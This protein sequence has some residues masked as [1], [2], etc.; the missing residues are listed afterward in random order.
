MT[1]NNFKELVGVI[2]CAGKGVRLSTKTKELQKCL[3]SIDGESIL[4]KIFA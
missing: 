1:E 4:Y 3:L 2:P